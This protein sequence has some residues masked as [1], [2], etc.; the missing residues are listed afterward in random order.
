MALNLDKSN[1]EK[2]YY[3]SEK[4]NTYGPFLLSV[5]ISKINTEPSNINSETLITSDGNKWTKA[6]ETPE[7]KIYFNKL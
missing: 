5:I 2:S 4:G 1:I 6:N 3:Y 7:L